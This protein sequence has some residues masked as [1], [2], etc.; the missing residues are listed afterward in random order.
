[1]KHISQKSIEKAIS[2]IDNLDDDQLEEVFEKYALQQETLLAY[3][4]MA[5][6]EYQNEKLEGLLVYYFCLISEC[7]S[8]EGLTIQEIKEAQIEEHLN[9]FVEMLDAFF[10]NEDE[11][12][13]ESY[14]DQPHLYQF[15]RMEVS[16]EDEDGTHFD[17]ETANQL[18]IVIL[19]MVALMN[20]V[21]SEQ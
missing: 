11:E 8:Q 21:N 4:M 13:P 1:M 16:T 18:F 6:T 12:I 15:L 3:L 14:I 5:P 2:V 17:D 20:N 10:E 9:P 19:S 7:F